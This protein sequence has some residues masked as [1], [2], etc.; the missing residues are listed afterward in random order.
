MAIVKIIAL[1]LCSAAALAQSSPE[2]DQLSKLLDPVIAQGMKDDPTP[3]LVL[4]VVHHGRV[5]YA[6]GF[7]TATLGRTDRPVTPETLFH[8][9]SITK[10]FVATCIMQLWEQ[11][12]I[13]LD[14]PVVQ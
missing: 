6:K 11:G 1:L 14:A 3:G 13:D 8:M 7:G 4:A 9:A 10:P 12:K 2:G 5:V